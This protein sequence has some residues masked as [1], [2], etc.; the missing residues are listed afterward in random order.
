LLSACAKTEVKNVGSKGKNIICFGDSLTFGYGA[1]LQEDFP[2]LLAKMTDRPVINAGIDGD[3]TFT[4]LNRLQSDV[5]SKDPYLVILEFCGNDFIKKIS[6]DDTINNLREMI[7]CIQR[8]GSMVALVDISAGFFLLEYRVL[9]RN[10]A[11]EEGAI[12]VPEVLGG[13]L[14]NPSMKSDFLHPNASGYKVLA[15][16]IWRAIKPYLKDRGGNT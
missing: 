15:E 1:N 16:R 9:F 14:T 13:I 5:L 11:R 10:L 3:T 12:F 7:R 6:R 8:Q 2:S 4:A